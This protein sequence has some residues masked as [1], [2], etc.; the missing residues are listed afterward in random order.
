MVIFDLTSQL[1]LN[2]LDAN[3]VPTFHLD[4]N[5]IASVINVNEVN[6]W[7][8]GTFDHGLEGVYTP[9]QRPNGS[10]DSGPAAADTG[11]F[12]PALLELEESEPDTG[13]YIPALQVTMKNINALKSATLE[14]S[15]MAPDDVEQ[16]RDP[17]QT[18]CTLDMSDTH[19]VKVL[20][21]FMYLT[22]TS[23][24]HYETIRKVDMAAYPGD[25]FLSFDQA[26]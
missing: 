4:E 24:D 12:Q 20:R 10:K 8:G 18:R 21:H 22:D 13:T 26:K 19:L 15:G 7:P 11:S 1:A 3:H 9:G 5:P 17:E 25:N 14:E 23:R 2:A 6:N 16:L